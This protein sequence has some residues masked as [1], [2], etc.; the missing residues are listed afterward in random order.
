MIAFARTVEMT[1]M[2]AQNLL[3]AACSSPS[4]GGQLNPCLVL[5]S[6]HNLD[7]IPL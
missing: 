3:D 6:G 2:L 5:E 1:A 7:P 4:G